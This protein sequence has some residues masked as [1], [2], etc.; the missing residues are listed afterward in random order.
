MSDEEMFQAAQRHKED[1]NAKFKAKA[2][3][4]AEDHYREAMY[5][6]NASKLD[7]EDVKKLRLTSY[8]NL[9][10]VLNTVGDYG[11]S[12]RTCSKAI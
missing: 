4:E 6:L 3:K 9:A 1:G 10:L 12:I 8:Q 2:M 7:N 5:N 11:E